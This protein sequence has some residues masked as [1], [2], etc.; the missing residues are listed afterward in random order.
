MSDAAS[1]PFPAVPPMPPPQP[2]PVE[3]SLRR[4]SS[5]PVPP[6][7]L[8][9]IGAVLAV[10]VAVP[11]LVVGH[12]PG[13]G[14]A[15]AVPLLWAPAV[16]TLVRRRA[17]GLLLTAAL[18][19][20]LGAMAAV[21]DAEW[22]VALCLLAA[23][24]LSAVAATGARSPLGLL[25]AVPT[26]PVATTRGVRWFARGVSTAGSG[27]REEAL[28]VLRTALLTLVILGVFGTLLASADAV[29]ASLL[30][31]LDLRTLPVQL[32]VGAAATVAALGIASLA[33]RRPPWSVVRMSRPAVRRRVEWYV[34]LLALDALML[35]FL[36]TQLVAA[37]GGEAYVQQIAG[38]SYASYARQGFGQ[39]V[40]V[41]ALTLAVVAWFARRA[42]REDRSDRLATRA[43]LA[44]LCFFAL[45]VVATALFR[46]SLYVQ[47]YGLTELRLLA[48]TG[49]IVM[50]AALLL[51]L[52]AGVRW[53]A[54]WL[55][56]AVVRVAGIAMLGLALLN[57]DAL[58]VR[59]N[60][61]VQEVPLD[62]W[63]LE[64]LS[65]DAVPAIAALED[66]LRSCLLRAYGATEPTSIWEWNH[67][68]TQAIALDDV[69]NRISCY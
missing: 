25:L 41:T 14:L 37:A 18:A 30:P 15:L 32:A 19:V 1:R 26:V 44:M 24:G 54:R 2:G 46:M 64:N 5:A 11:V 27:R 23:F 60:T 66:P 65:A 31:S 16:P 61:Q 52:V 67:A 47:A 50:G 22:V 42:P 9:L 35:A 56:L 39:L 17:W 13:L 43:C 69:T 58:M 36:L 51:V 10:G 7:S 33:V 29:F 45:G 53:R 62:T 20:A 48:T 12:E 59:Y 40:A 6:I 38:I 4:F 8:P 34:P 28:R 63:H 68:R 55:P 21:R 49:E 3:R 57:P